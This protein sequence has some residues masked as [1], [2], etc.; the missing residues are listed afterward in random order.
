MHPYSLS[1]LLNLADFAQDTEIKTLATLASQRCTERAFNDYQRSRVCCFQ[2]PVR[3]YFGKYDGSLRS[4][5]QQSYLF[6]YR[7][8]SMHQLVHL[9]QV[10]F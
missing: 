1:G 4:K 2:Q 3:N 7:F 8:W 6:A 10:V 5:S 9:T